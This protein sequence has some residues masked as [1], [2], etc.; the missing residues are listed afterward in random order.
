VLGNLFAV[1]PVAI[2]IAEGA[3]ADVASAQGGEA[4]GTAVFATD[5]PGAQSSNVCVAIFGKA[6]GKR[7]SAT[8]Y[9][10]TCS[11][12]ACHHGRFGRGE[13]R[14][15]A[16]T[17]QPRHGLVA[18]DVV[19]ISRIAVST[20]ECRCPPVFEGF[21]GGPGLGC[22][23]S[24]DIRRDCGTPE[25]EF[26]ADRASRSPGTN[27]SESLPLHEQSESHP[28]RDRPEGVIRLRRVATSRCCSRRPCAT[29]SCS[30]GIHST[31]EFV[32]RQ[33]AEMK[34]N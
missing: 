34:K 25:D 27:E 10:W 20:L 8:A 17:D 33:R 12:S 1:N 16:G 6:L 14:A 32:Q 15:R 13:K 22:S 11:D 9:A 3:P 30:C 7:C 2:V 23:I 19:D 24:H 26:A 29:T 31:D 18:D 21:P 28:G 4:S 5:M